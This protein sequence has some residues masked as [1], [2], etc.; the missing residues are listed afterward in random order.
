MT[1][2]NTPSTPAPQGTGQSPV[3]VGSNKGLMTPGSKT[4]IGNRPIASNEAEGDDALM[5]YLD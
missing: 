4:F 1:E 3:A 5:G 2:E